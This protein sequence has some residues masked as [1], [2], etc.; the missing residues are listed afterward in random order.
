[1]QR[2]ELL[3][4][5]LLVRQRQLPADTA[6]G[7]QHAFGASVLS[8][9]SGLLKLIGKALTNIESQLEARAAL[10]CAALLMS[11]HRLRC[12]VHG[13]CDRRRCGCAGD[14]SRRGDA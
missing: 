6:S 8:L 3:G 12:T 13:M 9:P 11:A 10:R 2:L 5:M 4:T 14:V 1:M 7:L